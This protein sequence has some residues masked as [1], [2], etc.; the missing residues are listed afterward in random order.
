MLLLHRE[1][2]R[3]KKDDIFKG[4]VSKSLKSE[5]SFLCT[6]RKGIESLDEVVSLAVV[7]LSTLQ[8]GSSSVHHVAGQ[9]AVLKAEVNAE[10]LDADVLHTDEEEKWE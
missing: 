10:R 2:K 5:L 3:K 6:P 1:N 8:Q 4:N 7:F 9:E